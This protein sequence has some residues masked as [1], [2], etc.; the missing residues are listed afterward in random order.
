MDLKYIKENWTQKKNA[1][2]TAAIKAWDSVAKS[3]RMSTEI[4]MKE[5]PF[6]QLLD[7]RVPL[8]QNMSVLDIGCGG[9]GKAIALSKRVASVT[10][11]DFSKEMIASARESARAFQTENVTF[12]CVDWRKEGSSFAGKYDLVFA[13][14]TPAVADYESLVN[15]MKASK[16]YC[17]FTKPA[18]RYDSV[19]DPIMDLAGI[20]KDRW[21][22]SIAWVFHTIWRHGCNPE[23]SY[24]D[25]IWESEKK[26]EETLDWY[27]GRLSAITNVDKTLE[28]K[29][30][31]YLYS[32]STDGMVSETIHTKLVDIF[33]EVQ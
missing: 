30:I 23:I 26:I 14:T 22:A 18:R 9:G 4:D 25:A 2:N 21:D 33:W 1:D 8:D 24:R 7:A 31:D 28:E 13:H 19:F 32:I 29:V 17:L 20:Q 15:M 12:L 6:L 3:F 11:I 16:K 10:G 5:D 27:L